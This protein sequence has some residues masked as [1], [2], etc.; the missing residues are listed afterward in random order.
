[1]NGEIVNFFSLENIS[2]ICLIHEYTY[3]HTYI[4]FMIYN[5]FL[6]TFRKTRITNKLPR[7]S[8]IQLRDSGVHEFY[9]IRLLRRFLTRSCSWEEG[10]RRED[11]RRQIH[12]EGE[13]DSQRA[14]LSKPPFSRSKK[15]VS[16][17]G[18]CFLLFRWHAFIVF[19]FSL[20]PL[21]GFYHGER[22]VETLGEIRCLDKRGYSVFPESCSTLCN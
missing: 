1:M 15:L 5:F 3:T 20:P 12:K 16:C 14:I 10:E 4:Y 21:E 13:G 19:H 11:V 9:D 2:S 8:N 17:S 18:Q 6:V 22:F 7:S